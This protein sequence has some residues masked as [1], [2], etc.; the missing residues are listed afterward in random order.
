MNNDITISKVEGGYLIE[1]NWEVT[2]D[3]SR[4]GW[5]NRRRVATSAKEALAIAK[6]WL[7]ADE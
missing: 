1:F 6:E 5:A 7:E 2:G 4:T 3:I